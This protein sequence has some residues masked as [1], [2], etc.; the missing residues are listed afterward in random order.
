MWRVFR[1]ISSRQMGGG[2]D[3]EEGE[4]AAGVAELA[5]VGVVGV[6]MGVGAGEGVVDLGGGDAGGGAALG[7]EGG[8]V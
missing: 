1:S 7:D 5:A 4:H 3:A 8:E 2:A 6:G